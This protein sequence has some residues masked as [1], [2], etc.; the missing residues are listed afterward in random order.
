MHDSGSIA[1]TL[2]TVI[3][4]VKNTSY[5][6]AGPDSKERLESLDSRNLLYIKRDGQEEPCGT[7]TN[8]LQQHKK[9][10]TLLNY[11]QS[12]MTEH[13]LKAGG[14]RGTVREADAMM[15]V[16]MVMMVIMMVR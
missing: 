2:Y 13:L 3:H 15:V 12:Y 14:P 11:F 1:N 10:V 8:Y 7:L 4:V 5:N 9:K 6:P 16:M